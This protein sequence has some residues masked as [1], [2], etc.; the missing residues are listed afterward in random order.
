VDGTKISPSGGWAKAGTLAA[1]LTL[2]GL[3]FWGEASTANAAFIYLDDLEYSNALP[4][5]TAPTTQATSITFP[6]I[7]T[8][9]MNISWTSGSGGGRVVKDEHFQLIHCSCKW[10]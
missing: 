3:G 7:T 1:D 10:F 4:L 6:A 8:S 2:G 5:C 9:D